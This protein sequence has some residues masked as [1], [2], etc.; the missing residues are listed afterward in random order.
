MGVMIA[1]VS[2]EAERRY[3]GQERFAMLLFIRLSMLMMVPLCSSGRD[4]RI[5]SSVRLAHTW[6][7]HFLIL[8]TISSDE[9]LS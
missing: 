7:S 6:S 2:T 9:W 1:N 8:R 3:A 4:C 5:F